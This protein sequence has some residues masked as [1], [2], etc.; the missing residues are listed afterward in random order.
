MPGAFVSIHFESP[1]GVSL[2]ICE[3][4]VYTDQ[5][6]IKTVAFVCFLNLKD[7]FNLMETV[8]LG[9]SNQK[10]FNFNEILVTFFRKTT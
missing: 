3:T 5:V 4:F 9:L 1:A 7:R 8:N 6:K 2:S 10:M